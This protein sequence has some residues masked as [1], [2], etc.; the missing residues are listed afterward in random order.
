MRTKRPLST[1]IFSAFLVDYFSYLN[2]F[3]EDSFFSNASFILVTSN[4]MRHYAEFTRMSIYKD[5][6]YYVFTIMTYL[7]RHYTMNMWTSLKRVCFDNCQV[8]IIIVT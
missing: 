8:T 5:R 4:E 2:I 3:V 1:K 7:L 6:I